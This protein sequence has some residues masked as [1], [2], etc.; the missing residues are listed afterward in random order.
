MPK[1]R[2]GIGHALDRAAHRDAHAARP[3]H[4]LENVVDLT[5]D[6]VQRRRAWLHVD[7]DDAPQCVVVHLGGRV[8]RFREDHGAQ[9]RVACLPLAAKR[10]VFELLH[11]HVLDLVG[12][13]LHGEHVVVAGVGVDPVAGRDDAVRGERSDDVVDHI[14]RR[15]PDERRAFAI[16]VQ[17]QAGILQVLRNVDIADAG[18]ARAVAERCPAPWRRQQADRLS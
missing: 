12:G 13:V 9:R 2:E 8:D 3:L 4:V 14:L 7:V 10:N 17:P 15:E 6:G 11:V 1:R 5:A 18:Q 16:N